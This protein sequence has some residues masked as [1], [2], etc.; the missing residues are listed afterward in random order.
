LNE[1]SLLD[2]MKIYSTARQKLLDII[3]NPATGVGTKTYYNTILQSVQN[4]INRLYKGTKGYINREIPAA[5]KIALDELVDYF[6][7]T[8][9][10]MQSP[11]MFAGVHND[12]VNVLAR[13]MQHQIRSGLTLAGR[14]VTRYANEAYDNLLRQAGLEISAV[15]TAMG[16]TVRDMRKMLVDKLQ[17]NG[18]L[19]VQYGGVKGAA[20]NSYSSSGG[21]N[22]SAGKGGTDATSRCRAAGAG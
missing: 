8:R 20:P 18:F 9:P 10:E 13:E 22:F 12:A 5:Y 4:T 6:S 1:Q 3:L 16:G 7:K 11:S 17:K 2:L 19:T 14:Q 15:K 21:G